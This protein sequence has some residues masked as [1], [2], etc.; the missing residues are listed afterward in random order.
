MQNHQNPYALPDTLSQRQGLLVWQLVQPF[1]RQG[2]LN[3]TRF[4]L[5]SLVLYAAFLLPARWFWELSLAHHEQPVAAWL[6]ATPAIILFSAAP[7]LWLGFIVRRYHDVGENWRAL[8]AVITPGVGPLVLIYTL[9]KK[10]NQGENA[11]GRPNPANSV[12]E[13]V[14]LWLCLLS[15]FIYLLAHYIYQLLLK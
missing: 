7:L 14:L 9:S 6:L 4:A 15:P 1:S 11:Y 3:R 13:S 5:F 2:R 12:L 10:T 8:L